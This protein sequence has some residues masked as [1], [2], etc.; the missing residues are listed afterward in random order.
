MEMAPLHPSFPQAL[1]ALW[2]CGY[3]RSDGLPDVGVALLTAGYDTPEPL[4]LVTL[5]REPAATNAAERAAQKAFT[6]LGA[7]PT[8]ETDAVSAVVA[9]VA[10][11]V[12]AGTATPSDGLRHLERL[13]RRL[14]YPNEP[15]EPVDLAVMADE[16]S[17]DRAPCSHIATRAEIEILA[18]AACER[19]LLK[20]NYLGWI[21]DP[22]ALDALSTVPA[23]FEFRVQ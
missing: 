6:S 17:E 18:P 23:E 19:L 16:W 1:R 15:A 7:P 3:I 12:A 5:Y 2:Q 13:W 22:V 9:V 21:P 20:L 4:D 10:G 11:G 8:G 14:D